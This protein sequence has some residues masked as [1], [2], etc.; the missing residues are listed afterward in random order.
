L[1][2][3]KFAIWSKISSS[4]FCPVGLAVGLH[5]VTLIYNK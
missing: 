3:E 2:R 4:N 5:T 1:P